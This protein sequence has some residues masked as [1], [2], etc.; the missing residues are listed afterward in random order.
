MR[1]SPPNKPSKSNV[2]KMFIKHE[3][4]NKLLSK[5]A[6]GDK[7]DSINNVNNIFRRLFIH[8]RLINI[9][10]KH[11]RTVSGYWREN[12][13]LYAKCKQIINMNNKIKIYM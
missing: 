4:Y 2:E 12:Y 11:F 9:L 6:A 3:N 10:K 13:Q 8:L 7:K 5:F 1:I